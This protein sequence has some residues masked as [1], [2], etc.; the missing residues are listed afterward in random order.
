MGFFFVTH[1]TPYLPWRGLNPTVRML[2]VHPVGL[3]GPLTPLV[4][5]SPWP[6]AWGE[7]DKERLY[8]AAAAGRRRIKPLFSPPFSRQ[9]EQGGGQGGGM[10]AT[11]L[12]AAGGRGSFFGMALLRNMSS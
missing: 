6:A 11:G 7:G 9:R 1:V 2:R 4:P 12:I 8:A 3:F 10:R 5:L